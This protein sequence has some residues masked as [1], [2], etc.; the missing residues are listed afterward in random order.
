MR[1]HTAVS[2]SPRPVSA[3][4][5]RS[6][7]TRPTATSPSYSLASVPDG[8]WPYDPTE[9]GAFVDNF[10]TCMVLKN[11]YKFSNIIDRAEVLASVRKG[12]AYYLNHLL[13]QELRPIPFAVKPRV[14]LHHGDLYD[15]AEG[16]DL[17]VLLHDAECDA[18]EV[19]HRLLT[20][21]ASEWAL[22]DGHFVTRQ[23]VL[24]RKRPISP[25]GAVAGV[26]RPCALL[27]GSR[28]LNV[29][30]ICGT[31][32]Y[33]RRTPVDEATVRAMA[34]SMIHRGPDD[35]GFHVAG[36]LALGMRRLSIIDLA[37][38]AQPIANEDGTVVVISNGEI[39]NF[40]ELRRELEAHGHVFA[41]Q[42]DTEV[43]VHG[44]E[45]WGVGAFARLNGMFATAVWDTSDQQ[46]VL[47]R[48][49]F[50]IKPLYYWD[51]GSAVAFASEIR[52]LFAIPVFVEQSICKGSI[53]S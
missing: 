31:Y 18:Q 27:P 51:D 1:V 29:C 34:T 6:M 21:L 10:H 11:L 19:L 7:S 37:G 40:R 32:N 49:I 39:Y 35:E 43:I 26:P 44:Y 41:T 5:G 20:R 13:D 45:Q 2:C 53:S 28:S 23:L 48:D 50:G 16:I 36:P 46:L 47:A 52:A 8:S 12:Y 33:G 22:A 30:G 38:G 9:E 17:A 15:Y 24:G 4:D 42:S 14:T 25:V 3:S